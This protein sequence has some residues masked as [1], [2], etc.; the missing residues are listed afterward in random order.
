[1][2][3]IWARAKSSV[4]NGLVFPFVAAKGWRP[5]K[6]L[7]LDDASLAYGQGYDDEE[8]ICAA[9]RR[10]RRNTMSS[11]ERL[12]TL[13]Q[14]VA[15]LDR[16]SIQGALVECGVWKGGSAGMMALSHLG[17]TGGKPSRELHLFD[18][19][20]GLP[21]PGKLDGTKAD[22]YSGHRMDGK[23][24]A[25]GKCVGP[26]EDVE[27]LLFREIGY[28]E[29]LVRFHKGWFQDTIHAGLREPSR[30]A[31]LRLDGDWYESTKVCLDHLYDRVVP[32]G[33]V[34][35]DDYGHWEGCKRAT[36]EFIAR[37][38]KPVY[39]HHIDYTGR[40]WIKDA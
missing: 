1:M 26:I 29:K 2:S 16:Y 33:I 11:F 34:V 19:F 3:G 20:E 10:V 31:L 36:D 32:G 24:E 39:L 15:H 6:A 22:S 7:P 12:A 38:G 27:R 13:W 9:I 5:A 17:A 25:I 28:P 8:K 40:Y 4:V 23:M 14:Q 21:E 37:L 35:M 30:I 18:S